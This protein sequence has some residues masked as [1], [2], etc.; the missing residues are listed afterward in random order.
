MVYAKISDERLSEAINTDSIPNEEEVEKSVIEDIVSRVRKAKDPIILVDACAIRHFVVRETHDLVDKSGLPVFSSPMGKTAVDEQH[1][2]YGGIYV[3][4]LTPP[5]VQKRVEQ[6]DCVISIGA[7][8]SDF[9][10][11]SFSY[12]LPKHSTIELHSDYTSIGYARYEGVA[13]KPM[14]PKIAAALEQDKEKRLA[15]TLKTVPS[16]NKNALPTPEEEQ[17][18][19][20]PSVKEDPN[21]ISQAWFWPRVGQ[22][23]RKGDQVICETGTSS[24]GMLDAQFPSGASFEAQVLWGSI[25]WSVGATLGTAL[26]AREDQLGTVCLF[27]GDGS[28]QLT[29]QEVGTMVR[30][31]LSPILF[32]LSNDGY[33]IERQIHGPQRSY[34]DIGAWNHSLLLDFFNGPKHADAK[35]QHS[36][37][38]DL[39]NSRKTRYHAV[40]TKDE[41]DKLLNDAEFIQAPSQGVIQL[42]EVFMKRGDAPRALKQQAAATSG[43]NKYD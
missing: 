9:N 42:V 21:I 25:G 19:T 43:A 14:L 28:L 29:V 30:E 23:F 41:L 4:N 32:V 16:M 15:E 24:F 7:L 3:G 35:G 38:A 8:L 26:A 11:G 31:G 40:K 10:T 18:A 39:P 37:K 6:A 13:M 17:E 34:N 22:F 20:G 5:K 33:E 12:R 27:V 1:P 2:Q 36:H